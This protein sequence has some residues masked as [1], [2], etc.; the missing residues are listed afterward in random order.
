MRSIA[1]PTSRGQPVSL[2]EWVVLAAGVAAIGWLNWYFFLANRGTVVARRAADTASGMAEVTVVVAGGYSPATIRAK[3]GQPLRIV[4][5]RQETSSCSEEIVF[6]DFG[7]RKFLPAFEKTTIDVTPATPGRYD[8]TCG[9][10]MLH[11]T[12]IAE[13]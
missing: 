5:D 10:S 8:F 1:Q 4:F 13:D 12:L 7:I 3:V 6:P 9:M 2:A 11:G